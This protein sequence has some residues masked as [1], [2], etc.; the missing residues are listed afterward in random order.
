MAK[1]KFELDN[2]K[3][4]F[5]PS[6]RKKLLAF[7]FLLSKRTEF[8]EPKEG[9]KEWKIFKDLYGNNWNDFEGIIFDPEEKITEFNYENFLSPHQLSGMD[10]H[11]K[12]FKDMIKRMNLNSKTKLEQHKINKE[13][14]KKIMPLFASLNQE[15]ADIFVHLI[16]TKQRHINIKDHISEYLLDVAC[17]DV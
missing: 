4:E 5:Y 12:S 15:E 17:S 1:Y 8:P 14:F 7:P 3:L 16:K 2:Q 9:Q 13:Q 6:D 11:S 10:T